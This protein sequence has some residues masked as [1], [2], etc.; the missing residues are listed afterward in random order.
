M[1]LSVSKE[2]G[3]MCPLQVGNEG[4]FSTSCSN[5][6]R[7]Y[8]CVCVC[9]CVVLLLHNILSHNDSLEQSDMGG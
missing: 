5:R 7:V 8:M 4:A 2:R 3:S 9:V 1:A 6:V